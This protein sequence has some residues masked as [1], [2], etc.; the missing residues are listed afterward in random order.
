MITTGGFTYIV[1]FIALGGAVFEAFMFG[2]EPRAEYRADALP[3]IAR[4]VIWVVIVGLALEA[5]GA[6]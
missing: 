1:A 6:R 5:M 4:T 2:R 3:A